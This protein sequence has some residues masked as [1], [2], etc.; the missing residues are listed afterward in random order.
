MKQRLTKPFLLLLA[1]VYAVFAIEPNYV[2]TKTKLVGQDKNAA[3]KDIVTTE[4]TNGF[5]KSLQSKIQLDEDHDRV[6]CRFY[7]DFGRL[8]YVTKPFVDDL[9]DGFFLPGNLEL[10]DPNVGVQLANSY[11][12]NTR[13]FSEIEYWDDPLSRVKKTIG[14][15]QSL[16]D[17]Y[18]R[19]WTIGV[20]LLASPTNIDLDYKPD[21]NASEQDLALVVINTLGMINQ[22]IIQATA[23][24]VT[25]ETVLD[26]LYSYFLSANPFSDPKYILT[27]NR[28]PEDKLS[29]ELKDIFGKTQRTLVDTDIDDV[30]GGDIVSTHYKYD[31]IGNVLSEF[32]PAENDGDK[33]IDETEYRYNTL[34]QLM[35]K[36]SPDA[37]EF[38][39][40]YTSSGQIDTIKSIIT[41]ED[42]S[43]TEIVRK[44]AYLYDKFGRVTTVKNYLLPGTGFKSVIR[45]YY[46]DMEGLKYLTI[47]RSI[48]KNVR[49]RVRNQKGRLAGRVSNATE[50]SGYDVGE[51]Y[52]YNNEGRLEHKIM[53]MRNSTLWQETA[54]QY[55]LHGRVTSEIFFYGNDV[56]AKEYSYD[57]LGR[58]DTV[59]HHQYDPATNQLYNKQRIATYIYDDHRG[60]LE[61][62]KFEQITGENYTVNYEYDILDRIESIYHENLDNGFTE[63]ITYDEPSGN[64]ETALYSY[65]DAG[66]AKN[67]HTVYEYDYLNRLEYTTET[68]GMSIKSYQYDYDNLGRFI[69]KNEYAANPVENYGY[70]MEGIT[71]GR[72]TN[73]LR[74]TSRNDAAVTDAYI[75][76]KHGNMVVDISKNMVIKYDWRDMPV[77]YRFY[78]NLSTINFP[79]DAVGTYTGTNDIFEFIAS[80]GAESVSV[81]TM[82]YDADGNRVCKL[83]EKM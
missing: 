60:I 15:G 38:V 45:N 74:R 55:D 72:H 2:R 77:I 53:V 12:S 25:I 21:P 49:F 58:L 66:L 70:Y 17:I 52:S 40:H 41:N 29:Q 8:K 32:P 65:S 57:E 46:D 81:V 18:S 78:E 54:Y 61:S 79:I 35:W 27:I 62:K 9:K 50:Y 19:S 13:A 71:T 14:P 64:V 51:L 82:F 68:E 10:S 43:S 36:K 47:F 34:G 63:F 67:Y 56:I 26:S 4:Y 44:I 6:I 7:D 20:E 83:E 75:Y 69:T 1:V 28:N 11:S 80:E 31:V 3:W 39:Y 59:Y 16:T 33:L 48:P 37:G 24:E 76:D 22:I 42:E 73:R 30:S 23:P 5:G